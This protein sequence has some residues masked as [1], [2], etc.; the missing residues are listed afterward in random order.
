[1][2]RLAPPLW[3][4]VLVCF[5]DTRSESCSPRDQRHNSDLQQKEEPQNH[6][7]RT[8]PLNRESWERR[9][10]VA[11]MDKTRRELT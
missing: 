1:M 5:W 2:C 11:V 10:N 9:R 8:K 4:G 3:D 6:R 7:R